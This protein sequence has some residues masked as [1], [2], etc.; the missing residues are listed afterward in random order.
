MSI[1]RFFREASEP[2]AT[3]NGKALA[4]SSPT[5]PTV[6]SSMVPSSIAADAE[7]TSRS[8]LVVSPETTVY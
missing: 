8:G 7:K 3:P 2:G 4:A 5:P 6:G 1:T